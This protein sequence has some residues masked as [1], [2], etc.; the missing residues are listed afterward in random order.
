MQLDRNSLVLTSSLYCILYANVSITEGYWGVS[1][2]RLKKKKI[3]EWNFKLK[4]G[5]QL[6]MAVYLAPFKM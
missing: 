2:Q 5:D 6:Y 3:N 4:E 1:L